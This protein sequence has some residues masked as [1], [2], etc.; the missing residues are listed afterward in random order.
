MK[1][2]DVIAYGSLLAG[3]ISAPFF[4]FSCIP[5][6]ASKNSG[7]A[8]RLASV[9]FVVFVLSIVVCLLA[10]ATGV[11]IARYEVI[12]RLREVG[13]NCEISINGKLV[14]HP[15]EILAVFRSFRVF[16]AHHSSPTHAMN[17]N[18]RWGSEQLVLRLAR[19]SGDPKEYWV[20]FP[21][22]SITSS[23]EIGRI[24]TSAFD[25]Y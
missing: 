18:I 1:V 11:S 21:K 22:Y 5:Y 4:L 24:K 17:I 14:Q 25:S 19:D 2:L 23:S 13:D 9:S 3:L 15:K 16:P 8:S 12:D 7:P 6:L 20:F 10:S